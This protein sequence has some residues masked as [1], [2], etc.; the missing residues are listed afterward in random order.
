MQ[1]QSKR[2]GALRHTLSALFGVVLTS[3][4]AAAQAPAPASPAAPAAAEAQAPTTDEE[5]VFY[6]VG[7]QIGRGVA[8][9]AMS[10]AELE[11]VIRGLRAQHA[12]NAL[13]NPDEFQRQV[14]GL[15]QSRRSVQKTREEAQGAA[16]AAAAAAEEGA[17]VTESG[18][19]FRSTQEGSGAQPAA[20]N[21]VKV[22]YRGT[23]RDGTVFDSSYDRGQPA[24]FPLNRVIPCWTEGLQRMKVGG[25]ATLVCPAA[26]AY[27]DRGAPPKIPPG[28]T[29]KFEVELLEI[30]TPTPAAAPAAAPATP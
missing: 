22:H 29:L 28:A 2:L 20:T 11:W 9:F 21:Q 17:Q 1:I 18:L 3:S 7:A 23:L 12:G 24:T 13:L 10:D 26:I 27:G 25:K 14:Q 5:K 19:I 16:F 30:V 6:A 4:L 15:I 8:I